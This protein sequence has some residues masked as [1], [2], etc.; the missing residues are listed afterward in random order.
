MKF[1]VAQSLSV[2]KPDVS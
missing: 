1:R 2:M